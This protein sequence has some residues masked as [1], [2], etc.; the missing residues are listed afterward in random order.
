MMILEINATTLEE[1][2]ACGE[3]SYPEEGAGLLLG[4][5]NGDRKRVKGALVLPNQRTQPERK[6]RYLLSPHDYLRGEKEAERLNLEVVGIFHSHPDHPNQPSDFDREW[7]LPWFSYIITSI[8]KGK[9]TESRAWT[10]SNDRAGFKE[11]QI[12]IF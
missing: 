12:V 8:Q 2:H 3:Q 4:E 6:K 9:A 1:I 10:L 7:A 11:E 5:V